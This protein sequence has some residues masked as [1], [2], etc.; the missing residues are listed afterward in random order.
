MR[1]SVKFDDKRKND[2]NAVAVCF[3][4]RVFC[5]FSSSRLRMNKSLDVL[6]KSVKLISK[7]NFISIPPFIL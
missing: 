3:E 5:C 7:C 4:T 2:L 1:F 6:L